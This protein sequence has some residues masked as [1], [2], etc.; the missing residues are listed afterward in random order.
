MFR[1][2]RFRSKSRGRQQ[3]KVEAYAYIGRPLYASESREKFVSKSLEKM[4]KIE[5][6]DALTQSQNRVEENIARLLELFPALLVENSDGGY[7]VDVEVLK[8]L[9]GDATVSTADEKYWLSWHGK[10]QARQIAL[11]PS[12]GTLL[13]RPDESVEW[14]GTRNLPIDGDNLEDLTHLQ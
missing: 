4:K 10:R 9:V 2:G 14:D 6:G 13:P 5:M 1:R 11:T 8:Q 3:R 7:A 12:T